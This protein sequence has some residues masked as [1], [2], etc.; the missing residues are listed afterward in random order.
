MAPE[1]LSDLRILSWAREETISF[2]PV[3]SMLLARWPGLVAWPP[4]PPT[5]GTSAPAAAPASPHAWYFLRKVAEY[6]FK[7]RFY[8]FI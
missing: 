6:I 4:T 8:L 1:A 3:V 2:M 5:L 7:Q